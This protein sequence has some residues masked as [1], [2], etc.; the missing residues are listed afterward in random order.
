MGKDISLPQAAELWVPMNFDGD[1]E[2]KQRNAHF[3]RSSR[4][5]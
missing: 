2:M 3:I 4:T 1:P 5:D